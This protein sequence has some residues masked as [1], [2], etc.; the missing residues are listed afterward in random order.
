MAKSKL[1][2]LTLGRLPEGMHWDALLPAFGIRVQKKA[3]TFLLVRAGG[4]RV[5]LGRYPQDL[6]LAQAREKA[7]ELMTGPVMRQGSFGDVL[8]AYVTQHLKKN[9]RPS[10]AK[11][12]ERLLRKDFPLTGAISMVT[13]GQVIAHIDAIDGPSAANHATVAIKA[14]FNWAEERGYLD[15]NP[16][17]KLA[18]PHSAT[19]RSHV[20]PIDQLPKIWRAAD[21]LGQFGVIFKLALLTGQRR[22][23]LA[24]FQQEWLRDD[25]IA[26]PASIMKAKQEFLFPVTN[27]TRPLFQQLIGYHNT[28]SKPKAKLNQ[29]SGCS[30]FTIHDCR[31]LFSTIH[32][33]IGTEPHLIRRLLAHTPQSI[34]GVTAVYLRH[35]FLPQMREA[36]LNYERH[37]L[38][39]ISGSD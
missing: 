5:K 10:Y 6:T 11:E 35:S 32:G 33:Q 36:L 18:K 22:N 25:H 2:D 8:D 27:L 17:A 13:K 37:T 9:C 19:T 39:I 3:R 31:R 7:R 30:G 24:M 20:I 16:I 29:L 28:W 1:Q 4:H 34:D 38:P 21:Q 26:F 14:L 12:A 15:R 23:Q